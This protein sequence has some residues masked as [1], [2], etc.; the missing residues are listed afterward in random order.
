MR[1]MAT[2][3]N[4]GGAILSTTGA[5]TY[6]NVTETK[7][8]IKS[9]FNHSF[10]ALV[11][12]IDED[13][14]HIRN[15]N[16]DNNDGFYDI[17]GYQSGEHF[18]SLKSVE[19]LILGDL[20]IANVSPEVMD[21]TFIDK[22]S[23][24]NTLKPKN[25]VCHDIHDHQAASHHGCDVFTRYVLHI[26][27]LDDVE[28]ELKLTGNFLRDYIPKDTN[29]I[30]VSSNH[31]DHF[32]RFLLE[33]QTKHNSINN[34][35]LYHKMMFSMLDFIDN[36]G[37]KPKAFELWLETYYDDQL[38]NIIYTSRHNGYKIK[39][40]EISQH[41]HQ[42]IN[43]A[44]GS[45][46]SYAKLPMKL[47]VGHSHSPSVFQGVYTVG[48]S[49]KL[50]MSYVVGSASSWLNCHCVVHNNGCRQLINII[51]GKWKK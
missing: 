28:E 10:G 1:T 22:N 2:L 27:K 18:T 16:G 34:T 4:S 42:G 24:V 32:D 29:A 21:A 36:K 13:R 50:D 23:I 33:F 15:L 41:G 3:G 35:K 44:K 8:G 31:N 14:F 47:V 11:V 38:P 45:S 12:E 7:A 17:D 49:S 39:D 25:I 30:I 19:A 46:L 6:P 9:E 43:G 48:T 37:Y 40:V 20:H 5:I 26:N 51:G